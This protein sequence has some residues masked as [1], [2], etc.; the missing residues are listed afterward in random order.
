MY[1]DGD[2]RTSLC[3]VTSAGDAFVQQQ[4]FCRERVLRAGWGSSEI[5]TSVETK[6]VSMPDR[7]QDSKFE[8]LGSRDSSTGCG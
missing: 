7:H 4:L 6:A 1:R 2:G 5:E 3:C 8:S